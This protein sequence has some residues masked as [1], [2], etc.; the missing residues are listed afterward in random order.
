MPTL[1]LIL[2]DQQNQNHPWFK[3]TDKNQTYA[4]Y[5]T[6]SEATYTRHH[7]QKVCAFYLSMQAF[8]AALRAAGHQV[9][10]RTLDET[11]ELQLETITGNRHYDARERDAETIR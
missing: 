5:E 6:Y 8:A 11:R 10:Y 1:N 7:V 2:G 3:K 4:L 9:I